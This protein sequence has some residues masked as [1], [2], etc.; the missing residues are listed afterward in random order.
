[1]FVRRS[2]MS[3]CE[4]RSNARR[5]SMSFFPR[6]FL[7]IVIY[8]RSI[9]GLFVL[10]WG[11]PQKSSDILTSHLL[12]S[13]LFL[14]VTE[15]YHRLESSSTPVLINFTNFQ[16]ALFDYTSSWK[17]RIATIIRRIVHFISVLS[18]TK[19]AKFCLHRTNI[20]QPLYQCRLVMLQ[21]GIQLLHCLHI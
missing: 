8:S 14:P 10:Y 2:E 15:K 17:H 16:I 13:T 19:Q 20:S 6:S 9:S 12:Y 18:N 7:W 1:M 5:C 3:A 11:K 4:T 21:K